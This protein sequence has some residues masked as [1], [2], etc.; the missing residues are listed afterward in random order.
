VGRNSAI[1]SG[2]ACFLSANE[3]GRD[4]IAPQTGGG[5]TKEPP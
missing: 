2:Q 3:S 4:T 5:T 1:H